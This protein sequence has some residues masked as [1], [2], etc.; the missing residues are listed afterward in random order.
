MLANIAAKGI[1]FFL[2]CLQLLSIEDLRLLDTALTAYD[3][4]STILEFLSHD[5]AIWEFADDSFPLSRCRPSARMSWLINKNIKVKMISMKTPRG[6]NINISLLDRF[7]NIFKNLQTIHL[8]CTEGLLHSSDEISFIS[9]YCENLSNFVVIESI[10]PRS[11]PSEIKYSVEKFDHDMSQL[12]I[13]NHKTLRNIWFCTHRR[14]FN[15]FSLENVDQLLLCTSLVQLQINIRTMSMRSVL[16][17]FGQCKFLKN[18]YLRSEMYRFTFNVDD[19]IICRSTVRKWFGICLL[20]DDSSISQHDLLKFVDL[21]CENLTHLEIGRH[22]GCI[23]D[24]IVEN[25]LDKVR[26][27]LCC[28]SLHDDSIFLL[29]HFVNECTHTLEVEYYHDSLEYCYRNSKYNEMPDFLLQTWYGTLVLARPVASFFLGT[30][31]LCCS[32]V[33]KLI[34]HNRCNIK[35]IKLCLGVNESHESL[36]ELT[37]VI[38]HLVKR[39]IAV[40]FD[41]RGGCPRNRIPVFRRDLL[42]FI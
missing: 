22:N 24:E 33:A 34:S 31:V 21:Y 23:I 40:S 30:E 14:S 35:L 28:I 2:K 25:L 6:Y 4:R 1:V 27:S 11:K 39:N 32:K 19:T 20:Q 38:R 13:T 9:N 37:D 3:L 42:D 15:E 10:S 18:V 41:V 7:V 29:P 5:K 26:Q 12:I 36:L 17:L 8:C 16:N